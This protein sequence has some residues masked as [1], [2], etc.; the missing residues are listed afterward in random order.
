MPKLP[1]CSISCG[2]C[3]TPAPSPSP[4]EVE[5]E[6]EVMKCCT[7]LGTNPNKS[8]VTLSN[9]V[10]YA[11]IIIVDSTS[12]PVDDDFKLFIALLL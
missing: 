4:D 3:P 2:C 10:M 9:A 6:E 12:A 7:N 5:E 1:Q 11:A 8:V